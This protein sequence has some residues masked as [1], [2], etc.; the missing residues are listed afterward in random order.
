MEA[1]L[2]GVVFKPVLIDFGLSKL[3]LTNE[4]SDQSYGSLLFSSPEILI[5]GMTHTLATDLWSLGVLLHILLSG[6][7]PFTDN[8]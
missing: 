7:F 5:K 2:G 1:V 8:N 6:L 4:R 3:F